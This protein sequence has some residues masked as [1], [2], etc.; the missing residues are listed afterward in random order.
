MLQGRW[1]ETF[2]IPLSHPRCRQDGPLHAGGDLLSIGPLFGRRSICE[3]AIDLANPLLDDFCF[4][5]VDHISPNLIL[6]LERS[7]A[8]AHKRPASNPADDTTHVI[9]EKGKV[10]IQ[11][12]K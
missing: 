7:H 11:V 3:C 1:T 5:F 4:N 2:L 12:P 9:S 6:D 10:V 8:T